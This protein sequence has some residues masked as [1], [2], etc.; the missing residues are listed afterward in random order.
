LAASVEHIKNV[1]AM[2][3]S[4]A[5]A[6]GVLEEAH[7]TELVEDALRIQEDTLGRHGVRVERDYQDVRAV[8]L[9]KT[10]VMQILVNLIE[11]AR[12][13]MQAGTADRTLHIA[14]RQQSA[15]VEVA[16]RD[17]GCGIA[18]EN[19][20]RIFAHGFTTKPG[21]HGFGLHSCALAA[22]EMGGSLS[23]HSDGPGTG[24][25]FTLRVLSERSP[26]PQADSPV[27]RP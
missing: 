4:Y 7:I 9:D 8:A 19:L 11:N 20:T 21:G 10:R 1:V 22:K 12:Q 15:H 5:G 27:G 14:V 13:A 2:Q 26:V 17:S 24:A 23:V 25:T 6:S 18:P 16:V 3:Q